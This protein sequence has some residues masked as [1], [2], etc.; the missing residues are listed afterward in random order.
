MISCS[1][2][3]NRDKQIRIE[4]T[5]NMATITVLTEDGQVRTL[6][7]SPLE[8][9]ESELFRGD[10]IIYLQ[11][12][13]NGFK[14]STIYI[15]KNDHLKEMAITIRMK[16]LPL[17]ESK[18]NDQVNNLVTEIAKAQALIY[19]KKYAAAQVVLE[20]LTTSHPDIAVIRDLLGNSLY[21]AGKNKEAL[22]VYLKAE[23]LDPNNGSRKLII[24]KLKEQ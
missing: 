22:D 16:E 6:G 8:I 15:P 20:K 19:Q 14:D 1:L 11:S 5:P 4:S 23:M 17:L 12:S 2:L 3:K 9:S 24:N 10:N 13:L 21:L 7:K 18:Q